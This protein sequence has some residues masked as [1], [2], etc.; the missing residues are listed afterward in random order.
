MSGKKLGIIAFICAIIF[1][2]CM[3]VVYINEPE[4]SDE[5]IDL[6][7]TDSELY[8]EKVQELYDNSPTIYKVADKVSNVTGLVGVILAIVSLVKMN[9]ANEK[10]KIF[11]VLA[12]VFIIGSFLLFFVMTFAQGVKAGIEAGMQAAQ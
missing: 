11:P 12:L 6:A 3:V 9:K 2:I 10:G 4:I 1:A 5:I 8:M 7:M